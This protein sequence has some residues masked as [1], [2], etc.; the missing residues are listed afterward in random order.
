MISYSLPRLHPDIIFSIDITN[1]IE[2]KKYSSLEFYLKDIEKK[3]ILINKDYK[4]WDIC[5]G[6]INPYEY[7]ITPIPGKIHSVS[8]FQSFSN[9]SF[10]IVEIIH[11]FHIIQETIPI[12]QLFLCQ[13]TYLDEIQ[14]LRKNNIGDDYTIISDI[15]LDNLDNI[16]N[17]NISSSNTKRNNISNSS[18][19]L[20]FDSGLTAIIDKSVELNQEYKSSFDFIVTDF[21]G[22]SNCDIYAKICYILCRQK[23]GG[24][25]VAKI[26]DTHSSFMIQIIAL[27]S[28]M[29]DTIFISKPSVS[30]CHTSV[31]FL[32][33]KGFRH[34]LSEKKYHILKKN[35]AFLI[36]RPKLSVVNLFHNNS[37]VI[38]TFFIN[39]LTEITTIMTKKQIENIHL[40]LNAMTMD[41]KK[42]LILNKTIE[43]KTIDTINSKQKNLINSNVEKCVQWCIF[44]KVELRVL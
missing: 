29:Y 32:V 28:S 40:T 18:S 7:L 43:I 1:D 37:N 22:C 34:N 15:A 9:F 17:F 31:K 36:Q 25:L 8:K 42:K 26:S 38:N 21:D 23:E 30:D 24:D 44:H 12:N 6:C 33:C 41:G 13:K 20:V 35:L 19:P 27:L 14:H 3:K 5:K 4:N 11:F 39:S 10:E 2:E 16:L